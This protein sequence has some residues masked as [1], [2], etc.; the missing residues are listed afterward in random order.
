VNCYKKN[1]KHFSHE[2]D[3]IGNSTKKMEELKEKIILNLNE[4]IQKNK[5][6]TLKLLE[7]KL[8][9]EKELEG[10]QEMEKN[11]V[12]FLNSKESLVDFVFEFSKFEISRETKNLTKL[13]K[14]DWT[15]L[16]KNDKSFNENSTSLVYD[17]HD[18]ACSEEIKKGEITYFEVK[19][20]ELRE[21]SSCCFVGVRTNQNLIDNICSCGIEK[22]GCGIQ[23][24]GQLWNL[25]TEN[26]LDFKFT[27]DK[28]IGIYLNL[29][30]YELN[31]FQNRKFISKMKLD[32]DS[33]YF[34][35]CQI[36]SYGKSAELT[37]PFDSL[38][39]LLENVEIK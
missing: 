33:I 21:G 11:L 16:Q 2:F 38:E 9:I 32:S 8:K 18:R 1:Q 4:T 28:L 6:K 31:I 35:C 12:N 39:Q 29:N 15:I 25:K 13:K 37:F 19:Y 7:E 14:F 17:K 30:N 34:C 20:T 24:N 3:L 26:T 23:S 5:E 10:C 36:S 22:L 27:S